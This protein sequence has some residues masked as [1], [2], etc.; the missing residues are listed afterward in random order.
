MTYAEWKAANPEIVRGAFDLADDMRARGYQHWSMWAAINVLR[1]LGAV[2][3]LSGALIIALL[4]NFFGR[5]TERLERGAELAG[6]RFPAE[7]AAVSGA[8]APIQAKG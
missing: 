3:L 8:G 4:L 1:G 5:G 6:A 7:A 2:L